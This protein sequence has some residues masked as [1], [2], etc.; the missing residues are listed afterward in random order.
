MLTLKFCTYVLNI[1][2]GNN[3]CTQYL[4]YKQDVNVS[5]IAQNIIAAHFKIEIN[6]LKYL[7]ST[8]YQYLTCIGR[9]IYWK[10]EERKGKLNTSRNFSFC[11]FCHSLYMYI[12]TCIEKDNAFTF[13]YHL[14]VVELDCANTL[15][16][17]SV[18]KFLIPIL[19]LE[20]LSSCYMLQIL[21][22][23]NKSNWPYKINL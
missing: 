14:T 20:Q 23:V 15:Q 16:F 5:K 4:S 18:S 22:P 2:T 9:E 21:P 17:S 11:S 3:I 7:K 10:S 12:Y 8:C 13:P 6:F 1:T 19:K